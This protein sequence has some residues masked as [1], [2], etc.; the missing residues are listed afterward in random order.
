MK[1]NPLDSAFA[2]L[3]IGHQQGEQWGTALDWAIIFTLVL[4]AS[5]IVLVMVSRAAYRGRQEQPPAIW[6]NVLALGIF[7]VL[8]LFFGNFAVFS[9]AEQEQFCASCHLT[10][11]P[12]IND[13]DNPS[14]KSL[15]AWHHQNHFSPGGEEACYTCHADYGIHGTFRAKLSGLHDAYAYATHTYRLPIK[16]RRPFRNSLCL[17]C[18]NSTRLFMAVDSHLGEDNKV[19]SAILDNSLQCT[20]CHGPASA[21]WT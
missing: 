14:S 15:A 18:H 2:F 10:M 11:Q 17:K 7:P 3:K 5:I 12:Y 20:V 19:S 16:L 6:L 9:Y 13:I 1:A 4:S 21:I 8:L